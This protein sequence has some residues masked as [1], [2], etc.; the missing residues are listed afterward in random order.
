MRWVTAVSTAWPPL[1][2]VPGSEVKQIV[3]RGK[4]RYLLGREDIDG[5]VG[6]FALRPPLAAN[7]ALR[8]LK[9]IAVLVWAS[10]SGWVASPLDGRHRFLHRIDQC[11][12]LAD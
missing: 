11:A 12:G 3:L 6:R 9:K 1:S 4:G 7:A 8:G 10:R 2:A 5:A